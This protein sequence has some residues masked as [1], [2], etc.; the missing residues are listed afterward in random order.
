MKQVKNFSLLLFYYALEL[1]LAPLALAY[2]CR[3]V[4][5]QPDFCRG[6]LSLLSQICSAPRNSMCTTGFVNSTCLTARPY[7]L[8]YILGYHSR[9]KSLLM[10]SFKSR[11][12]SGNLYLNSN[13]RFP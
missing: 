4:Y 7:I 8:S 6:R 3:T 9:M 1:R 5:K 12:C 10:S 13:S 11:A 2:L